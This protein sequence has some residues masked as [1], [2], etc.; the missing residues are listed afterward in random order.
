MLLLQGHAMAGCLRP[1]GGG[2]LTGTALFDAGAV[3]ATAVAPDDA[4]FSARLLL[5][6]TR[7]AVAVRMV[8]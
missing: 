1:A 7:T 6:L 5:A 4:R 8:A 2:W 3:L